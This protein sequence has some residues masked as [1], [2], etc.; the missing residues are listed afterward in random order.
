MRATLHAVLVAATVLL[1][2]PASSAY[3]ERPVRIVVPF[4]AGG[5]ADLLAR[6]M[7]VKMAE[8]WKQPVVVENKPGA[9]AALGAELVARSAPDGYTLLLGTSSSHSVGPA[10]QRLSYDPIRDFAPVTQVTQSPL[11]I[12]LHPAVPV[13]SVKELVDYA[14]AHPGRLNFASWGNGSASHLAA[15]L[16]KSMARIDIVHV[17]YKGS[18]PALTDL[19][20]GQVQLTFDNLSSLLPHVRSGK[21]KVIAVT[22]ETRV[23]QAPEVPT[24]AETLPGYA[25]VGWFGLFAPAGTPG[26]IVAQANAQAVR[27]LKAPEVE[28]ALSDMGMQVVADSPGR[29]AETVRSELEKWSAV[30]KSSGA[31]PE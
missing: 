30:V 29:F 23:P 1:A 14:R 31:R 7:A 16:F 21:L 24:V 28:K 22:T 20:A 18:P 10:F 3:P 11:A 15:E 25:A 17:P 27:A 4:P 5:A 26:E 2:V 6:R 8:A 9:A 19:M 13:D 12:A